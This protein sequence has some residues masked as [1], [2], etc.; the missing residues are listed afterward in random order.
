[1]HRRLL[2]VLAVLAVALALPAAAQAR[3][4]KVTD[5]DVTLRLARD[6]SVIETERLTVDY[7]G[8]YNAT[9]R[10]IPLSGGATIDPNSVSVREGSQV[11][12]PGG[13]TTFGCI[14]ARGTFGVADIPGQNGIRI[15]WHPVA[16]DEQRTF[17]VSYR[18]DKAVDA[19]DDVLDVNARVWGDQWD[20]SLDHLTAH[21]K[22]PLLDPGDRTYAVWASPRSVEAKTVRG[23]GVAGLAAS[24]I[25]A[26]QYV[27]LRVTVP[28]QP[29]QNVGRGQ[30]PV[31]TRL[32]SHLG[33]GAEGN[34]RLQQAVEQG[35]AL[36]RSS[37]RAACG[38]DH[39]GPAA[40]PGVD[41]RAGAG[42]PDVDREVRARATG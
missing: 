23:A 2:S 40:D 15:V 6:A 38:A 5:A 3:S 11:Y 12:R 22:S 42:A 36:H 41:A 28:R 14:D 1:M 31:R 37:R 27:E 33:G 35:Q 7:S 29:G 10:D 9:Y 17:V 32:P 16:S 26:H 25:P 39:L 30:D 19:Y 21:L 20:F 18:V 8:S 24:G 13:C 34:G 4:L